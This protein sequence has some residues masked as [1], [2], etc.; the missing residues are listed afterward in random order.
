MAKYRKKFARELCIQLRMIRER[1]QL[2]LKKVA[3]DLGLLEK[4][5]EY[6]ELGMDCNIPICYRLMEYYGYQIKL[7]PIE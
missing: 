2:S 3:E 4:A 1:K 7:M 6:V 5:I